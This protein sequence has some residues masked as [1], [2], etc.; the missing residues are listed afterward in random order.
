MYVMVRCTLD[1]LS[2]RLVLNNI[3]LWS[4]MGSS[5]DV[6]LDVVM[7]EQQ[8]KSRIWP[9][10]WVLKLTHCV[11]S[12]QSH[13]ALKSLVTMLSMISKLI[14][15]SPIRVILGDMALRVVKTVESREYLNVGGQK[16]EKYSRTALRK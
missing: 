9:F 13:T 14:F 8:T 1:V 4:E 6:M 16:T 5:E 7:L 3:A 11:R 15:K 10:E 12:K 2:G